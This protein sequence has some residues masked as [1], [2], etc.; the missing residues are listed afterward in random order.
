MRTQVD[1]GAEAA[2]AMREHRRRTLLKGTLRYAGSVTV[3]VLVRD[4]NLNGA[5]LKVLQDLPVPDT[6]DLDLETMRVGEC[7][8]AWRRDNEMGVRF[9]TPLD[10]LPSTKQVVAPTGMRGPTLRR[11]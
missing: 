6:F 2:F 3:S 5:K 11:V 1:L 7:E 10:A 4:L 8:V 9:T